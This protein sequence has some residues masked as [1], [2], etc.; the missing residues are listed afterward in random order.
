[1][2]CYDNTDGKSLVAEIAMY[3]MTG[4]ELITFGSVIALIATVVAW[5]VVVRIV[6]ANVLPTAVSAIQQAG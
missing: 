1:M 5:C 4:R 6:P 2:Y 3:R